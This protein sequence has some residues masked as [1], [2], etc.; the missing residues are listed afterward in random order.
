MEILF[1]TIKIIAVTLLFVGVGAII[2]GLMM[3][4][5]KRK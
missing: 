2:I 4:A 5:A 1:E 3:L